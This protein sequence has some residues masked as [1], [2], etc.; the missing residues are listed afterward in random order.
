MPANL[1]HTQH[2]WVPRFFRSLF[3]DTRYEFFFVAKIRAEV[4]VRHEPKC[5]LRRATVRGKFNLAGVD[6]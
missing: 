4:G 1:V 2:A 3:G 5:P 6:P